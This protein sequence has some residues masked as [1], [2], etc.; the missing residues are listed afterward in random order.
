MV[1]RPEGLLGMK[2][3]SRH[4]MRIEMARNKARISDD[5]IMVTQK[6]AEDLPDFSLAGAW[7]ATKDK[8]R[9]YLLIRMLNY[10]CKPADNP[11]EEAFITTGNVVFEMSKKFR[12]VPRPGLDREATPEV[13]VAG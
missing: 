9:S 12:A 11:F 4:Q 13:E 10:L 6:R 2:E 1:A 3:E 5:N 7:F 8:G